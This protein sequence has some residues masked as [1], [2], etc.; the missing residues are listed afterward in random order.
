MTYNLYFIIELCVVQSSHCYIWPFD[1]F[2]SEEK[3]VAK[4]DPA[5]VSQSGN[6]SPLVSSVFCRFHYFC[7]H[8]YN[9]TSVFCLSMK[10]YFQYIWE[11]RHLA[12]I[13]CLALNVPP[14]FADRQRH[15]QRAQVGTVLCYSLFW[16]VIIYLALI[17][18]L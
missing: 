4:K 10:I 8:K 12:Y 5:G 13:F 1:I 11:I 2:R 16:D 6:S 18:V 14:A 17:G 7:L 15:L 3:V 9:L